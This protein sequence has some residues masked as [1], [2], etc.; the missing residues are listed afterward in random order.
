MEA[1]STLVIKSQGI[2]VC[3]SAVDAQ[4]TKSRLPAFRH[5]SAKKETGLRSGNCSMKDS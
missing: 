5:A 1:M 4:L 3:K 2:Y